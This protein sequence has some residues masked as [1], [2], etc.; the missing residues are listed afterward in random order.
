MNGWDVEVLTGNH[1]NEDL[2]AFI[3]GSDNPTIFHEPRFL[4]YHGDKFSAQDVSWH[5]V[6]LRK[7]GRIY[8]FIPGAIRSD[9]GKK[10]YET[11]F[12]SSMGGMLVRPSCRFKDLQIMI[13]HLVA[14]LRDVCATAKIGIPPLCYA[15]SSRLNYQLFLLLGLGFTVKQVL[16]TQIHRLHS[17]R[18]LSD[19]IA[20]DVWS[21]I[22]LGIRS[23]L[24]FGVS[25]P[26][27]TSYALLSASQE[28][29]GKTPTHT[30]EELE[31]IERRYPGHIKTFAS[32]HPD[33]RTASGIIG[34]RA[35]DD[36]LYVFYVFDDAELRPCHPGQFAYYHM[37]IWAA[38]H[39]YRLVDFGPSTFGFEP[40]LN[41]MI[42]KE[43]FDTD[44]YLRIE[45]EKDLTGIEKR[46]E[47]G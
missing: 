21:G 3:A 13:R 2:S 47:N 26:D 30:F 12:A 44:P 40:N 10:I 34:F 22:N 27:R 25:G 20:R 38:D 1:Q 7:K 16:V 17:D 11:P 24:T 14:H 31:D 41:L 33:G 39:G 9:A 8:G 32:I 42:F 5:H 45:L 46:N 36:V 37:L 43:K 18:P 19:R 15:G 35:N 29:F 4:A 28:R 23:G 6:V